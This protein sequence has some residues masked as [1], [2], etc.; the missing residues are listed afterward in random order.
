MTFLN[1]LLLSG[2]ATAVIP[3]ILHFLQKKKNIVKWGAMCFLENIVKKQPR[4]I[5]LRYFSLLFT[6]MSLLAL[7]AFCM[8]RPVIKNLANFSQTKQNISTLIILDN[9]YSMDYKRGSQSSFQKAMDLAGNALRRLKQG[10]EATV[11][12]TSPR[13]YSLTISPTVDINTLEEK[14]AMAKVE[15]AKADIWGA[16]QI[17]ERFLDKLHNPRIELLVL[18]DFQK[19][20]WEK[21]TAAKEALGNLLKEKERRPHIIFVN[22]ASPQPENISL[23]S[24]QLS[25]F[26][27]G[28]DQ[29]VEIGGQIVNYGYKSYEDIEVALE[30]NGRLISQQAVNL[31]PRGREVVWF[32][33]AFKEEGAYYL[34]M[35]ADAI[36]PLKIDD[37]VH[38][39][40]EVWDEITV[41]VVNGDPREDPFEG[42]TGFLNFALQPPLRN[43][44]ITSSLIYTKEIK[45]ISRLRKLRLEEFKVII[46]ANVASVNRE[47]VEKL[48]SFLERGGGILFFL[49]NKVNQQNY[50]EFLWRGG[51]GLLPAKLI[52]KEKVAQEEKESVNLQPPPYHH[53]ALKIFSFGQGMELQKGNISQWYK[54]RTAGEGQPEGKESRIILRCS[55]QAPFLVEKSVNKGRVI[56]CSSSCDSDWN[57]LPVK[58]FY[59]PLVHQLVT[60]VAFN[61]R[62]PR[63]I[64]IGGN[65]ERILPFKPKSDIARVTGPDIREIIPIVKGEY[66]ARIFLE[67]LTKPGLYTL[68]E[69]GAKK[70]YYVVQADRNESN[71][72]SVDPQFIEKISDEFGIIIAE[73]WTAV[74]RKISG[75]ESRGEIWRLI[76]FL[77]LG[78]LCLE[79]FLQQKFYMTTPE[80]KVV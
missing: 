58:S 66:S 30:I 45:D 48:N 11:I 73:D 56:L 32:P 12:L 10:D 71:L 67:N 43:T 16:F 55:N 68:E 36:L 37:V 2:V 51:K 8:A 25:R 28:K 18:S 34:K 1:I 74:Q 3:L 29:D 24:I 21:E 64:P 50:N 9:S 42:E 31:E 59:L 23:E 69:P 26:I 22:C 39:S 4:K 75:W 63:N 78:M 79:V 47:A 65:L 76:L 72:E 77:V 7:L 46:L 27:V 44:G 35:S 33:F 15:F 60:Y 52:K 49:G 17:A 20:Q 57:D 14:L 6:R 38:H 62:P 53:P 61:T 40:L 54:V 70:S 13:A 80:K 41:L 19:N 5:I